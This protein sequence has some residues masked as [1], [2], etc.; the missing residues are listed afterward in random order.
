MQDLVPNSAYSQQLKLALQSQVILKNTIFRSVLSFII[1]NFLEKGGLVAWKSK[2]IPLVS[3]K[4]VAYARKEEVLQRKAR[5]KEIEAS[6]KEQA[7]QEK[8]KAKD[9]ERRAKEEEQRKKLELENQENAKAEMK[10]LKAA[11][12]EV[13]R[14]V[15]GWG[16]G[17]FSYEQGDYG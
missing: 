17:G 2:Y 11:A 10:R 6:R 5:Q 14:P 7:K 15:G 8:E 3:G 16:E 12:E 13:S 9:E 1:F 4:V